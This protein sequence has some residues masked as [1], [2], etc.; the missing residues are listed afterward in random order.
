MYIM[1]TCAHAG[2][3]PS[4]AVPQAEEDCTRSWRDR[5]HHDVLAGWPRRDVHSSPRCLASYVFQGRAEPQVHSRSLCQLAAASGQPT[6]RATSSC[7]RAV[8]AIKRLALGWHQVD[9][10]AA[11][12]MQDK[13]ALQPRAGCR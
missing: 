7:I 6:L 5:L 2:R 4:A 13:S 11:R 1:K 10:F 8:T 3:C 9:E 12:S